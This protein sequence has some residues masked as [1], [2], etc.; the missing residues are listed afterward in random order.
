MRLKQMHYEIIKFAI[1]GGINT[2]DYYLMYL[3]LLKLL[4]V[5]YMV[6]HITGFIVGF[7]ISYYLD[8]YF[9]YGVK[10]ALKEFLSL[11]LIQVVNM[12]M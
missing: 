2:P 10:P 5:H 8:C 3:I 1:V 6:G 11:P 4:H 12:G 7:I 9:A